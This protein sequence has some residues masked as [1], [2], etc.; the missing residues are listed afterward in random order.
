MKSYKNWTQTPDTLCQLYDHMTYLSMARNS[1]L[2]V[3]SDK[4]KGLTF[5]AS[6]KK[7]S[8]SMFIECHINIVVTE[9]LRVNILWRVVEEFVYAE[10]SPKH[11]YL[12]LQKPSCL[13][14]SFVVW[15]LRL[16]TIFEFLTNY[17]N[18]NKTY[19]K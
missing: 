4:Q 19:K 8:H 18:S 3:L 10:R 11:S 6:S 15:V 12:T 1:A 13:W 9:K 16:W 2:L 17:K 14:I 7:R 5:I